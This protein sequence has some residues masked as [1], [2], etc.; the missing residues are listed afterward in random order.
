MTHAGTGLVSRYLLLGAAGS[1]AARHL[2]VNVDCAEVQKVIQAGPVVLPEEPQPVMGVL[3]R[4]PT[5]LPERL[6][7]DSLDSW[8]WLG[9]PVGG[10]RPLRALREDAGHRTYRVPRGS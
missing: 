5:Y 10:S 1:C 3:G 6:M 7:A 4:P 9:H 2:P 8:G